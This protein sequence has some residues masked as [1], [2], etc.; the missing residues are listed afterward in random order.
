MDYFGAILYPVAGNSSGNL[1]QEAKNFLLHAYAAITD[2]ATLNASD[3]E[4]AVST[5]TY[6]STA[7]GTSL[8]TSFLS[9]ITN[10][11]Y[12]ATPANNKTLSQYGLEWCF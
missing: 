12:S 11:Y 3:F 4:T 9:A 8:Q 5:N 2:V 7:Q 1:D 6:I 10:P